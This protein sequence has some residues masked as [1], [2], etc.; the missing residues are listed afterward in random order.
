MAKNIIKHQNK[1]VLKGE[2]KMQTAVS[3]TEKQ[4]RDNLKEADFIKIKKT[5]LKMARRRALNSL[6][7]YRTLKKSLKD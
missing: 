5:V 6:Y 7:E 1:F 3:N 2:T 4:A